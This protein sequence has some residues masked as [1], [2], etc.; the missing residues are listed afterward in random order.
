MELSRWMCEHGCNSEILLILL[1][2]D[3]YPNKSPIFFLFSIKKLQLLR[4]SMCAVGSSIYMY[5][6]YVYVNVCMCTYIHTPIWWP[7]DV[8]RTFCLTTCM[9]GWKWMKQFLTAGRV[10]EEFPIFTYQR[11]ER[12]FKKMPTCVS[13]RPQRNG[14][15]L[16]WH[17]ASA[18]ENVCKSDAER[19]HVRFSKRCICA[20]GRVVQWWRRKEEK[21][22][23]YIMHFKI[24]ET[25]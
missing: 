9:C 21:S 16:Q 3:F 11:P 4:L 1:N 2:C 23:L 14:S 7:V 10:Y 8:R 18:Y 22:H 19:L 24:R 17:F 12:G 6:Q 13:T 5:I 20:T 15:G 25:N